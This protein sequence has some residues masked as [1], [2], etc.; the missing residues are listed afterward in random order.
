MSMMGSTLPFP[1]TRADRER[2]RDP[3]PSLEER[4]GSRDGYLA[5]VRE[6]LPAAVAARHVLAEDVE[7][8]VER[9][10]QLWDLVHRGL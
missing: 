10:G 2:A 3:R 1:L 4:Y 9:A 8:I 5:R 7:A 6:V